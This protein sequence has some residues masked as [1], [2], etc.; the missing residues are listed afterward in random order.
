MVFVIVA[1][2]MVVTMVVTMMVD[3][4]HRTCGGDEIGQAMDAVISL[5]QL[6][7]IWGMLDTEHK[8]IECG[9]VMWRQMKIWND[10]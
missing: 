2:I 3:G 7:L 9:K 1:V 10:W 8:G 4:G 5:F 6:S